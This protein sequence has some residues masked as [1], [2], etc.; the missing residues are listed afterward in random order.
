[1]N[2]RTGL[3]TH[4]TTGNV[5]LFPTGQALPTISNVNY[6]AGQT[7]AGNAIVSLSASGEFSAYVGQPLGTTADVVIDV[8]GYFE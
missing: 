4:L 3:P 2:R 8:A 1:M 6:S 7:R 5:R